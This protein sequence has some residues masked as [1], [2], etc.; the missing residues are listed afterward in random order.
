MKV[1]NESKNNEALLLAADALGR[2]FYK[3]DLE[4]EFSHFNSDKIQKY[5]THLVN[6][7][8]TILQ[9]ITSL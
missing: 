1:K 7:Y 8:C 9:P 5:E 2:I 4:K 6:P 3:L